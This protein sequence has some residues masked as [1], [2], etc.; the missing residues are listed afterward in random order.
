[1]NCFFCK[2]LLKESKTDHVVTLEN[3]I[4][5]IKNVPCQECGQCG[6]TY[7]DDPVAAHLEEIVKR[8]RTFVREVAV[9]EYSSL[10]A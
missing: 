10:V 7:Y 9:F 3:C 5:I 2:G 4:L 6:E 8:M 1:M